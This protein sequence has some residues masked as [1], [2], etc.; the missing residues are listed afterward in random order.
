MSTAHTLCLLAIGIL[1]ALL[2]GPLVPARAHANALKGNGHRI[3]L[4][5]DHLVYAIGTDGLNRAFQD[6][7]TGK[8]HLDT[9]DPGHFMAVQKDGQW[10]GST[11][12]ELARGFLYVTFGDSDIRAKVH[13]RIR[14]EYLTLEL[15]A[16]NDH[17][18]TSLQLAHL[19][20]TLTQHISYSLASCRDDEYAAAVIPLNIET[21][22]Y[23]VRGPRPLLIGHADQAVRLEGA[24]IAI[25]GC[26]TDLL[27]DRIEQVEIEN[28]L[29]HSTLGGVWAR[30]SPEHRSPTPTSSCIPT[31]D[32]SCPETSGPRTPSSPRRPPQMAS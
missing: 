12:V 23:P 24:R 18:I 13:I 17:T 15:T 2:Y 19:P 7:R 10:I 8:D 26:P 11:A 9:T 27:L 28:G 16:V 3:L 5:T 30:R 25:L 22:A 14:S 6:R 4:E 21:H 32:A 31:G 20:L 29:P 1:L